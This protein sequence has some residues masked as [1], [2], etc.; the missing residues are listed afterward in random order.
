MIKI[1]KKSIL[2]AMP[3]VF[4]VISCTPK[5]SNK[6]TT[7]NSTERRTVFRSAGDTTAVEIEFSNPDEQS[8]FLKHLDGF[9]AGYAFDTI[10]GDTIRNYLALRLI[11]KQTPD[12]AESK[13]PNKIDS[14]DSGKPAESMQDSSKNDFSNK[15]VTI[16][17]DRPF[18]DASIEQLLCP[19]PLSPPLDSSEEFI[20][21]S[22]CLSVKQISPRRFRIS[23]N[24]QLA[25]R[26]GGKLTALDI[27]ESWSNLAR[28]RPADAS[29]FLGPVKGFSSFMRGEET[30]LPGIHIKD[31]Q[32][33]DM[34]YE[35]DEP[36]ALARLSQLLLLPPRLN[37]GACRVIRPES[38]KPVLAANRM[39]TS[40]AVHPD[41]IVLVLGGDNNPM[42]SLSLNKYDAVT[43]AFKNDI[44]YAAKS[45][46]GKCYIEHY[47]TDRYF[48]SVSV[49]DER[50]RR[51]A[52]A[53]VSSAALLG[54]LPKMDACA[55]S[56]IETSD[57][58]PVAVSTLPEDKGRD[59]KNEYS[60][61]PPLR[62]LF[63]N[64][65]PVS[66]RIAG[67]LSPMLLKAGIE[68]RLSGVPFLQYQER[69]F[70]KDY[71]IA[72]GW[73]DSASAAG[74]GGSAIASKWFDEMQDEKAR[75]EQGYEVPLFSAKRYVLC[76]KDIQFEGRPF[77]GIYKQAGPHLTGKP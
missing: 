44:D 20:L 16:Y 76:R 34:E 26:A 1:N 66:V 60:D 5:I 75:I 49:K 46:S 45:L 64:D 41:S 23:L 72:T 65:D 3:V 35:R 24:P 37:T 9:L 29:A 25:V 31:N 15:T 57:T 62:I 2:F 36:N 39:C 42:V 8:N 73:I 32:T 47:A 22:E 12:S 63:Q 70:K 48:L 69:L 50:M 67:K 43:L 58:D 14:I 21:Q 59:P 11:K 10:S 38:L 17:C 33:L 77:T 19:P 71:D 53:S 13:Q 40:C 56:S 68:S 27:A 61:Q 52:A 18:F 4:S 51:L 30:V 55:I 6:P 74:S 54:S 7:D 28:T